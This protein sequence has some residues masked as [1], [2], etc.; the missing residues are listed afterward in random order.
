M[1]DKFDRKK[2]IK[3]HKDRIKK[4]KKDIKSG[5]M[6]K[7]RKKE[8]SAEPIEIRQDPIAIRNQLAEEYNRLIREGDPETKE[9]REQIHDQIQKLENAVEGDD[10][11]SNSNI[12]ESG[13]TKD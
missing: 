2:H 8:E 13:T 5:K 7:G 3:K 6:P 11:T 4:V 9:L 12:E 10:R 1:T